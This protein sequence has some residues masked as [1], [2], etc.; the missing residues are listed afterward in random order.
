MKRSAAERTNPFYLLLVAVGI[1]FLITAC[2]YG[3][4]AY[5]DV[6]FSVDGEEPA[7]SGLLGFID[8]SG[9]WR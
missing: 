7:A 9:C 2:A 5:R 4:M 1:A 6:A 8:Q 3:L